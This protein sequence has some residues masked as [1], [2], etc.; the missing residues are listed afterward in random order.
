MAG[1]ILYSL[2]T[3]I[4]LKQSLMFYGSQLLLSTLLLLWNVKRLSPIGNP[5]KLNELL[6]WLS[7]GEIFIFHIKGWE[8]FSIQQLLLYVL[9]IVATAANLFWKEK[10]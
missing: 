9:A 6:M 10:H 5:R 8:G 1:S 2:A 7:L 4:L 3:L